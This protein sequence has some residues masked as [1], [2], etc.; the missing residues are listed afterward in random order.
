MC[1]W[2]SKAVDSLSQHSDRQT[3]ENLCTLWQPQLEFQNPQ[4]HTS[5]RIE[6]PRPRTRASPNCNPPTRAFLRSASQCRGVFPVLGGHTPHECP[7]RGGGG[8]AP[9]GMGGG[10]GVEGGAAGQR[11]AA[12]LCHG[13]GPLLLPA[14]G[15]V[16]LDALPVALDAGLLR[17]NT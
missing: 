11:A 6:V 4:S 8:S 15:R 3:Q 13:G 14:A 16:R 17:H 7:G 12:A 1:R 9:R 10:R 5:G 2:K